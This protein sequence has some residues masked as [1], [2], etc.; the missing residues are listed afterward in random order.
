MHAYACNSMVDREQRPALTTGLLSPEWTAP[1]CIPP[2]AP[3]PLGGGCC[4]QQQAREANQG[5]MPKPPTLA[6]WRPCSSASRMAARCAASSRPTPRCS[7]SATTSTHTAPVSGER[8]G[9]C[10]ALEGSAPP[11]LGA[12]VLARP[13]LSLQRLTG[14]AL[15]QHNNDNPPNSRPALPALPAPADG[16][17]AYSLVQ[18]FPKRLFGAEGS[19]DLGQSLAALGLGDRA[20]LIMEP[21]AGGG[22]SAGGA[23][24][25]LQVC[26]CVHVYACWRVRA[27]FGGCWRGWD[28]AGA[29]QGCPQFSLWPAPGSH[30]QTDLSVGH[31]R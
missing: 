26:A 25:W 8:A 1:V 29:P 10:P 28:H 18:P 30:A 14:R 31:T 12:C 24:K 5:V 4:A 7:R 3:I 19:D 11:A 9:H 22:G 15:V 20:L 17:G 2:F 16:G 13:L 23:G 6:L 21:Q 27:V